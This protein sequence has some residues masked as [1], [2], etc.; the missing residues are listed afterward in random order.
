VLILRQPFGHLHD[1]SQSIEARHLCP[2]CFLQSLLICLNKA[3]RQLSFVIVGALLQPSKQNAL[4]QTPGHEDTEDRSERT[5]TRRSSLAADPKK[6]NPWGADKRVLPLM[7]PHPLNTLRKM[8]NK[9]KFNLGFKIV[10]R[11][12]QM[13]L[14]KSTCITSFTKCFLNYNFKITM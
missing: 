9:N 11:I 4:P 12:G 3:A 5:R 2:Q 8:S 6:L 10:H 1:Y 7:P 13:S 14:T